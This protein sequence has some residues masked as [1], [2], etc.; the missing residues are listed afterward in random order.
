MK[1]PI[2]IT[3]CARSGTSMTA[4]IIGICGAFGGDMFGSTR[5][6]PRGMYENKIIREGITKPYLRNIKADPMCQNP[7]PD[8]IRV[9]QDAHN[10]KFI[11][12]WRKTVQGIMEGQGLEGTMPWFYKGAKM[13]LLWPIWHNA[14]P[15]AKWVL[16]RRRDEDIIRSCQRTAFM[17][18]YN[19]PEG[20]QKWID[21]HKRRFDEMWANKLQIME[22]WPEKAIGGDL[23]EIHA[24]LD[25]LELSV[26][27]DL[28]SRFID[29]VLW[30]KR[31]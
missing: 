30:G 16:V 23:T 9:S 31:K 26:V 3:G 25:W 6:N 8:I 20:W 15:M 22:V 17:R 14:F 1:E 5:F 7:L 18:A 19:T 12:Q 4:G 24:M 11:G 10:P 13:A 2:L 28:V 29:P 21:V 27:D